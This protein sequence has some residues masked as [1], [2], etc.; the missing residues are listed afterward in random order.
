MLNF[1]SIRLFHDHLF[2][3]FGDLLIQVANRQ[4]H[5]I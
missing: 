1:F 4:M 2:V 3:D 5:I